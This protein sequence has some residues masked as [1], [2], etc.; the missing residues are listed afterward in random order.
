MQARYAI[1]DLSTG[2]TFTGTGAECGDVLL[3]WL[4][5]AA[6]DVRAAA[7]AVAD[8]L[9]G[10][11]AAADFYGLCAFLNV[12]VARVAMVEKR[13]MV[14]H[15]TDGDRHD[16]AECRW[17]LYTGYADGA[18]LE[19]AFQGCNPPGTATSSGQPCTLEDLPQ[20]LDALAA[21]GW[22]PVPRP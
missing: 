7:A 14:R 15:S 12:A 5:G 6:A 13:V 10:G 3:G 22:T 21:D 1:T 20:L 17:L 2:D 9:A 11:A 8:D 18:V 16:T 4:P 19:K